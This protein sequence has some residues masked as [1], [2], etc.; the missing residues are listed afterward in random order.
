MAIIGKSADE[1]KGLLSNAN[2]L[3]LLVEILQ[4]KNDPLSAR[5]TE[6]EGIDDLLV[7]KTEI[8]KSVA[9]QE[10]LAAQ[11][12]D[13]LANIEAQKQDIAK[14]ASDLK[15]V[16][17]QNDDRDVALKT[18]EK[19]SAKNKKD[20]EKALADAITISQSWETKN[21]ELDKLLSDNKAKS[22]ELDASIATY[23]NK[24]KVLDQAA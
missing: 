22:G 1:V 10:K 5:I 2:D 6:L 7:Q 21:A 16:Q 20:I 3:K 14:L 13:D 23:K 15:M 9:K 19:I 18:Q 24:L 17:A 8:M 4:S 11:N 12:Q